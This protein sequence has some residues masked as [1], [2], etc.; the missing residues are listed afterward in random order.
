[1]NT[2]TTRSVAGLVCCLAI[3]VAPAV[4]A[5]EA[6]RGG[7]MVVSYKDDIATLDS[8]IGYDWQNRR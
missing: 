6:K 4:G 1:M 8:A 3:L 5:D 2:S 7:S